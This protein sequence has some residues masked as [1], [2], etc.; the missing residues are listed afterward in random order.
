MY[1][2]FQCFPSRTLTKLYLARKRRVLVSKNAVNQY[3]ASFLFFALATNEE[4]L[5][6]VTKAKDVRH[7]FTLSN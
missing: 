5:F 6:V 7:T 1:V 4:F 3:F 2:V